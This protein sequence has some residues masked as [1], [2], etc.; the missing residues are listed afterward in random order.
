MNNVF[1]QYDMHNSSF[2]SIST[3][4]DWDRKAFT[5]PIKELS[6]VNNFCQCL[7]VK[8]ATF[9]Q[10]LFSPHLWHK[11]NKQIL[12]YRLS[13]LLTFSLKGLSS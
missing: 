10:Y 2:C 13:I 9:F 5:Q 4:V 7:Q 6:S 3:A 12:L 11:L 1:I 8:F